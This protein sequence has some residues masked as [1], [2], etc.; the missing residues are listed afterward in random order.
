MSDATPLDSPQEATT[1]E[2]LV[3]GTHLEALEALRVVLAS[4]ILDAEPQHRASLAR[5]LRETMADIEAV[6]RREK[7]TRDDLAERRDRLTA[8]DVLARA[9]GHGVNTRPGGG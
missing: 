7:P 6:E 2:R 9:A 4:T 3:R 8:S 5:Q 1:A